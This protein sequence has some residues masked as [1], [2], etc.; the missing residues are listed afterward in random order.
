[1]C[2]DYMERGLH[3]EVAQI[4]M[5]EP[6]ISQ[7]SHPQLPDLGR[8]SLGPEQHLNILHLLLPKWAWLGQLVCRLL[9]CS[10]KLTERYIGRDGELKKCHHNATTSVIVLGPPNGDT[11]LREC[12]GS[13][14][15]LA[16]H[17]GS[18]HHGEV[19]CRE[20]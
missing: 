13:I 11:T 3:R 12:G 6:S 17:N 16:A 10:L 1:M 4:D 14:Q 15:W 5:P 2:S 19:L 9:C 18:P 7:L 8:V 20:P